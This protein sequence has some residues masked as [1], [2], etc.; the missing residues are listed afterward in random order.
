MSERI[1]ERPNRW[2]LVGAIGLSVFMAVLDLNIVTV[3]L[4]AIEQEFG[5][6]TNVTEWVVLGYAL[7]M[8]AL[9]LPSGRWLDT[10]GRRAALVFGAAGFTGAGLLAGAAQNIEW[11]IA[12]RIVQGGFGAVLFSIGPAIAMTAVRPE[13]RGRAMGVIGTLGPLGGISGPALGGYLVDTLGWP[14]IFYL[15]LPV[16]LAII[17]LGYGQLPAGRPLRLPGREW[18]VETLLLG[19]AAAAL[20]LGLSAGGHHPPWLLLILVAVPLILLWLRRPESRVVRR[21]LRVAGVTGPHLALLANSTA[22]GGLM[23]IAPFYLQ[24]SLRI[25]ATGA[26]LWLLS[27]PAALG[28][29]GVLGGYLADRY[30][31]QR[32]SV[33]GAAIAAGAFLLTAPLGAGWSPVDL[34]WRL[35]LAGV[36]VGLFNGPNMAAVMS[37]APQDL[38]GTTGAATSVARQLGL[39]AGPALATAVWALSGYTL[40]GMRFAVATAAVVALGAV[41]ALVAPAGVRHR[42]GGPAGPTSED[43]AGVSGGTE[44]R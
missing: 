33:A 9:L 18:L 32:V 10:I 21:L 15:N 43:P 23:L 8:V 29:V 4:P 7:P 17:A 20:L 27:F 25:S 39:G 5:T 22:V 36:G 34:A 35:A 16:G 42:E 2:W 28:V 19:S 44:A 37:R 13:F 24:E 40:A 41:L 3:A 38:L 14:W 12:A 30:G 6:G 11:L 31:A 26:G 1:D